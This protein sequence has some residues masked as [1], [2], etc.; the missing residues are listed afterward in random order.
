MYPKSEGP[1]YVPGGAA[2]A[3][4]C[5]LCAVTALVIR[6]VLKRENRI[7]AKMEEMVDGAAEQREAG[8]GVAQTRLGVTPGFRYIL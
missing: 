3:A 7:L 1:Q 6:V 4:V 8:A 5:V 2:T